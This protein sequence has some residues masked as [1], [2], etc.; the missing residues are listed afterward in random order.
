MAVRFSH[1]PL[2]ALGRGLTSGPWTSL[3]VG[4]VVFLP[5]MGFHPVGAQTVST[6]RESEFRSRWTDYQV[7]RAKEKQ[8]ENETLTTADYISKF[9]Q[10]GPLEF[11]G[12]L[13]SG[14][15]YS[16]EN[17]QINSNRQTTSTSFFLAPSLLAFYKKDIGT[18]SL[19]A[20]YSVGWLYY[21]DPNYVGSS[22]DITT[23]QTA[24]L[25]L[26][27]MNDRVTIRSTTGASSGTGFDIER[28]QNTD[29]LS[30]SETFTVEYQ[31]TDYMRTGVSGSVNYDSYS[32][33]DGNG[34]QDNEN[35]RYSGSV[36]V[37][38]F[39]TDKTAY[40]LEISSGGDTQKNGGV[41]GIE[42]TYS[43]AVIR[44]N[45]GPTSKLAF[46]GSLGAGVRDQNQD[47]NSNQTGLRTV[48]SLTTVY[49]PSEKTSAR[50]YFGV[51]GSASLP[52]FSLA[53]NWHPR[54]FTFVELSIYQQTGVTSLN[55]FD[56][57]LS[58]G[59]L[60]SFRQRL[61]SRLD[62]SI[63]AG[64]EQNATVING[65][66]ANEEDPYYFLSLA[67]GWKINDYLNWQGT[68]RTST[69]QNVSGIS[70][71]GEQTRASLSLS[72][73]F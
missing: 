66:V 2:T 27:R 26:L 10:F 64:Y 41:N 62:G 73:T 46:T 56:E 51:E 40:R 69:R 7:D 30:V 9:T 65:D 47:S 71:S 48:F 14:W 22:G 29:R 42:R 16:N 20:Q 33:V 61:F 5:I 24:N 58:K 53:L 49:T 55:T 60:G 35:I 18:W 28:G 38:N 45:W 32:S 3:F 54:E 13:S 44:V 72:L 15:E 21:L 25:S 4:G 43:Q 34:T 31:L 50:L 52:E 6:V 12:G 8:K 39:W 23:S 70:G 67:L 68:I 37:D 57:R 1:H 19:D 59:V 17:Y 36:F 11:H 63:S